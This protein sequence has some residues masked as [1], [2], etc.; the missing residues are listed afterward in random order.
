MTELE[1]LLYTGL[2]VV[3]IVSIVAIID[4]YIQTKLDG[5]E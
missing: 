2:G 4:N 5:K 3:S 1:V